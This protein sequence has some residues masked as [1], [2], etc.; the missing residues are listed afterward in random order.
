MNKKLIKKYL[1]TGGCLPSP[2]D[3]RDYTIKDAVACMVAHFP[4]EFC[5]NGMSVLNQGAVGSCV[6]HACATAMGYGELQSGFKNAHNFSRGYIY[7]NRRPTDH[8]EEGMIVRQALKQLNHCGDCE[9]KDF[10]YNE[11]YPKVKAKIEN[12]KTELAEKAA[13]FKILN[14]FRCY[15]ET[16]V[17]AALMNQGAVIITIP[18]YES[19]AKNCPLPKEGEKK[20]GYHAMCVIGWNKDGWIIQ[21]SW[22]AFWGDKGKLY[23]PYEYPITEF[24]GIT[25]NDS[26]PEPKKDNI[27]IRIINWI[28]S[29]FKK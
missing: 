3:S 19:F 8:Q 24:W 11:P 14:Y 10:P 1:K 7:G 6:A 27:F 22:S 21:N 5:L 4:E 15:S 17:K 9:Y 20:E 18:V 28:I 16:E 25:I 23:L 29:L 13:P 2:E 26:L 12:N